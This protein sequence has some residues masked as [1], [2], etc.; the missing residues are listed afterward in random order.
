VFG[1]EFPALELFVGYFFG[2]RLSVI[3]FY[4]WLKLSGVPK[5][6]RF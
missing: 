1:Y 4:A 2:L 3:F 5:M 6:L